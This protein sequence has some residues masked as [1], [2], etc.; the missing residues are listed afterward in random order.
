M[1]KFLTKF[2]QKY[3]HRLVWTGHYYLIAVTALFLYSTSTAVGDHY[4]HFGWPFW[5][6]MA[7]LII[8]VFFVFHGEAKHEDSL[9]PKCAED[10]PLNPAELAEGKYRNYLRRKHWINDH[11]YISIASVLAFYMSVALIFKFTPFIVGQAGMIAMLAMMNFMTRH[12]I[13][14]EKYYPWCPYCDHGEFWGPVEV[15]N[16][17]PSISR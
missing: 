7:P 11:K 12:H 3:N 15:P 17:D 1:K 13:L 2:D 5:L 6:I 8:A 10:L 4:L 9:C 16:P 14:H